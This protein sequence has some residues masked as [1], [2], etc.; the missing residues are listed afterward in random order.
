MAFGTNKVNYSSILD[1]AIKSSGSWLG[2][3]NNPKLGKPTAGAISVPIKTAVTMQTPVD[4]T[5]LA[6]NAARTI[7]ALTAFWGIHTVSIESYA[8]DQYD[9]EEDAA[10]FRAFLG[11]ARI[12]AEK[13]IITDLVAGTASTTDTLTVGQLNF[14]YDGTEGERSD[15]LRKLDSTRRKLMA[16]V[17]GSA[18]RVFGITTPTALGN[19]EAMTAQMGYGEIVQLTNDVDMLNYRGQSPIFAYNG[20][21]VS[22]FGTAASADAFYWVHPDAEALTWVDASSPHSDLRTYGDGFHKKFFETYGFAGLIQSTHFATISNG[23]S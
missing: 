17:A 20:A 13:E 18:G 14:F 21:S 22:G 23:T 10:E 1:A 6:N 5:M 4:G 16:N 9:S 8:V 12:Y 7:T 15:N 19:I 3:L 2:K 11:A